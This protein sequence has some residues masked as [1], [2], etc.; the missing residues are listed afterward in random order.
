MEAVTGAVTEILVFLY[1]M[2]GNLGWAIILFT[3]LIRLVLYPLTMS[4]LRASNR[5]RELQPEIKKLKE[6]HGKNKEKLQAAQLELYKKYNV[7]PLAGCLPQIVQ[8]GVLILLYTVL[9]DFL[10][11]TEV[12]GVNI[13]PHFF[14]L[15]LG[16]PDSTYVLPLIAGASQMVLSIMIAPGSEKRDI[17]P[18]K[19]KKKAVQE[20]NKKEEG[21]AEMAASMQQQMLYILPVMTVILAAQF[22]SG[23][24]LYWTITTVASVF[25]QWKISGWGGIATYSKRAVVYLQS[26]SK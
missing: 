26:R 9:I 5:M 21:F 23:L 20:A 12:N 22:P 6:K 4:S 1:Q 15:N 14:Y 8:L 11:Q 19:S 3:L 13:D 7:N 10:S 25:Q 24:A 16:L 2:S 17:I 18:N